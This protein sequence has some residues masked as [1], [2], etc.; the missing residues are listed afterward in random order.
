MFQGVEII[1]TLTTFLFSFREL[2]SSPYINRFLQ[3]DTIIPDLSNPQSWNRYSYVTNRPVNFNDPTGHKP[4]CDEDPASCEKLTPAEELK[5][6]IKDEYNWDIQGDVKLKD[7]ETIFQ[8]G[9]DIENYVDGLTG[10]KGNTWM[11]KYLGGTTIKYWSK[12]GGQTLPSWLVGKNTIKL[13][14]GGFSKRLF[15]HELGHIWDINTG[16]GRPWGTVGGVADSLNTFIGG[17][18]ASTTA[19]RYLNYDGK[20]A[21]SRI[22]STSISGIELVLFDPAVGNGYGNGS[23]ADYLAES[24]AYNVVNRQYTPP[25]A[26]AWIDQTIIAQAA[27]LP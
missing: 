4:V 3:P 12:S 7:L 15:T 11:N 5:I 8:T 25:V 22:K 21:D 18:I 9:Q 20:P 14:D 6:K 26:A 27:S 19:F 24:F 2:A 16:R 23:T 1:S 10:G 17:D 13:S